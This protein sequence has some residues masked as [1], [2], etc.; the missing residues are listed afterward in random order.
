MSDHVEV[1]VGG[2]TDL[3]IPCERCHYL[4]LIRVE[5][6]TERSVAAFC[7]RWGCSEFCVEH[8]LAEVVS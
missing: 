7:G 8:L 5:P 2:T 6:G 4:M 3:S 1:A